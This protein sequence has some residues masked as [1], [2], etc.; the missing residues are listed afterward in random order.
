MYV[1][2][3]VRRRFVRLQKIDTRANVS[4]I[5]TKHVSSETLEKLLPG[6]GL[7]D[8]QPP[9]NQQ[10]SLEKLNCLDDVPHLREKGSDLS[11]DGDLVAGVLE[12]GMGALGTAA[13]IGMGW[14]LARWRQFRARAEAEVQVDLAVDPETPQIPNQIFMSGGPG[15][16]CFHCNPG[17]FGLRSARD[18]VARRRCQICWRQA[19][20]S[21]S[22][23]THLEALRRDDDDTYMRDVIAWSGLHERIFRGSSPDSSA[24]EA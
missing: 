23:D 16:Q 17:C 9:P 11:K 13:C 4:D 7:S 6:V 2:E 12:Y 15:G 19:Q 10:V 8:E 14:C 5:F 20:S 22:S 3:L 24:D 21:S 1:K 18:V